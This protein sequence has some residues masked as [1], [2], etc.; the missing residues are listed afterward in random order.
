M[1]VEMTSRERVIRALNF[2]DTDRV[3]VDFGGTVVTC[4]DGEA[5]RRLCKY[6]GIQAVESPII[7]WTMGTVEPCE[8]L[9]EKFRADVRRVG[10][11]VLPPVIE[12]DTYRDGFGML[13]RRARPHAYFDV[14]E[15]S[16]AEAEIED[17]DNM[18]MPNPND[19]TLYAGLRERTRAL[20]EASTFAIVADFG[21]PGFYE[22][23]Q[24][25]LGYE[26]L[27]CALLVEQDLVRALYDRLLE[28]QMKFWKRYLDEVGKYAQVVCY[29]DDLGMQDRLQMSPTVYRELIFPY[30]K[31]IFSFIHEH[32]DAKILLHSCG[33]IEPL[34]DDLIL[35]GVNVI[36]P[37]QTRAAGMEPE[38]LAERYAGRV[39]FWGGIDVQNV[40]PFGTKTE[41]QLEVDRLM[42]AF[43]KTGGYVL[44]PAHNFQSDTPPENIEAMYTSAINFHR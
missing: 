12:N 9:K 34:I 2:Q 11:N 1:A 20:W 36:N 5:H 32:T 10:M 15:H 30:H 28:L 24:K 18:R 7:D 43:A 35:A 27:A 40:L 21:I 14:I 16:L 8:A 3:P 29:A 26:R 19:L 41:V 17:L 39:A 37:L 42:S 25:L 31:R 22:T 13:L 44:A 38:V 4:M 23:S 33:A 6:F